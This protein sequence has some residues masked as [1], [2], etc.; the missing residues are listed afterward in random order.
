[1]ITLC[2]IQNPTEMLDALK[3][4]MMDIANNTAQPIILVHILHVRIS[5]LFAIRLSMGFPMQLYEYEF[6]NK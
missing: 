5:I 1:M 2:H 4:Y 6:S 3:N